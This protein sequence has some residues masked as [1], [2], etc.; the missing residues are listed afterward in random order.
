MNR[1]F[2]IIFLLLSQMVFG[3]DA[4]TLVLKKK[5]QREINPGSKDVYK[6]NL[7]A[8]QFTLVMVVQDGVDLEIKTIDQTGKELNIFD[9]PNGR[10]GPEMV[11]LT[12]TSAGLYS[13]EVK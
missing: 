11:T 3:Q 10:Q 9:S 13:I 8:N 4:Q 5:L 6:V 2:I 12:S 1:L 7:K